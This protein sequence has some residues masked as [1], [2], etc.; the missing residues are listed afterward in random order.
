MRGASLYCNDVV[1][2]DVEEL[3][4]HGEL[5]PIAFFFALALIL[6]FFY[7]FRYLGRKEMQ[8]TVRAALERGHELSPELLDRL[9]EPRKSAFSDFRRGLIAIALAV[10]VAV[11]GYTLGEED[12]VRP[13]VAI[14]TLPLFIGFAYIILWR[15]NNN[16]D[17][18]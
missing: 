9:G 2:V 18:N 6:S 11:F 8:H 13:L 10:A 1:G 14:A 5:I 16:R 12:A 15:V 7:Y 3:F 4:M 17:D